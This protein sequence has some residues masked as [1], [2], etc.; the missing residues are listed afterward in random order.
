MRV[1]LFLAF[2]A[3]LSVSGPAG[4][5]GPASLDIQ[6][7]R[8]LPNGKYAVDLVSDSELGRDLRR[9]VM[10]K[11][12]ARGH[13]VGFSGGH[14]M[15]L[16]VDLTRNFEGSLT[17]ESVLAAP[18]N[19]LPERG[20]ARPPMPERRMRDL[21]PRP[22]AAPETLRITL[23]LRAAG[24]GEVIWVAYAACPFSDG[25]ALGAGRNMIDAIFANP[26]RS[27]RGEA[28]CPI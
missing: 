26:N 27:R 24:S 7:K 9:R 23:T 15:R 20:D 5:E 3:L 25:R 28:D 6:A 12:A 22:R 21:E 13:Q 1:S 2:I 8:P 17:P 19:Q 18:R 10:E 11:L 4:A 16:Q 14:V